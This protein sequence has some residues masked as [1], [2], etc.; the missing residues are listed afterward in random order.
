MA[1][2]LVSRGLNPL[3]FGP[4][5]LC[6]LGGARLGD[7]EH[8]GDIMPDVYRAPEVILGMEWSYGVDTWNAAMVVGKRLSSI[9]FSTLKADIMTFFRPTYIKLSR[10]TRSRIFLSVIAYS[11]EETQSRDTTMGT[12]LQKW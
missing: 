1:A 11:T 3:T 7:E 12:I 8:R 4:P 6:D 10:Q 9:L 5:V 2:L